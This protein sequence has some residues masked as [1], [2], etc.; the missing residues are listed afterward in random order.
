MYNVH[1]WYISLY[2]LFI[3]IKL[4]L[5]TSSNHDKFNIILWVHNNIYLCNISRRLHEINNIVPEYLRIRHSATF[6][7][8][9]I[10]LPT[11][12]KFGLYVSYE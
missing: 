7:S 9:N 4:L 2:G 11:F 1:P 8:Y 12:H 10:K 3:P 6:I 5:F